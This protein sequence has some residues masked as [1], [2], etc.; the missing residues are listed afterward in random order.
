MPARVQ[1]TEPPESSMV[2][3]STSQIIRQ[4]RAILELVALHATNGSWDLIAEIQTG[5]L[6]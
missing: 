4:L 5:S 1:H 2:G 3:R 6:A